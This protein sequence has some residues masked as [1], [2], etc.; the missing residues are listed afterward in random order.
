MKR[1][2]LCSL[3]LVFLV[4]AFEFSHRIRA[5]GS[6]FAFLIPDYETD[7]CCNPQILKR[8]IAGISHEPTF[9]YYYRVREY[10]PIHTSYAPLSLV[11]LTKRTGLTGQYWFDYSH[12]LEPAETGWESSTYRAYRIQD[13]WLVRFGNFVANI[14]NDLD[15]SNIDYI[16]STNLQTEEQKFE[17][18]IRSQGSV[19]IGKRMRLDLKLGFGIFHTKTEVNQYDSYNKRLMTGMAR[20]GIYCRNL[21]TE[22]DFTSWY[23]D[24]GSPLTNAEIDSLPYSV[25]S[26][27]ANHESEFTLFAKSLVCR[28][29]IAKAMPISKRAFLA[30]GFTDAFLI[31]ATEDRDAVQDLNLRGITNFLSI[32]VAVEYPVNTV[33][34][35]LGAKFSYT[36]RNLRTSDDTYVIQQHLFHTFTYDLS[37]GIGWQPHKKVIVDIY[38]N[39]NLSYINNWALYVKYLF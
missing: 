16:T 35:R 20:L 18:T 32:P 33:T 8:N 7:L 27:V 21:T 9:I 4:Q 11:L 6:D 3:I 10:Y 22:N 38:N 37:F 14:R 17:Y 24:I 29:G 36:F 26:H 1:I 13:L 19:R 23:F 39:G 2:I 5:L 12:D 30:I 15:H 34:L 25:Y 28:C 31:Q